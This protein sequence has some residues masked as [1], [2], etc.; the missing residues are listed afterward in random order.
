VCAPSRVAD[1][2]TYL[3]GDEGHGIT[4]Q[5]IRLDDRPAPKTLGSF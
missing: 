2:V 4:G 5:V 1:V 3:L